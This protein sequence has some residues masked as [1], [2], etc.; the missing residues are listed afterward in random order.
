MIDKVIG[1]WDG[2]ATFDECIDVM[3]EREKTTDIH[4]SD[5]ISTH[6]DKKLF[7]IQNHPTTP[8]YVHGANQLMEILG[9][10]ERWD[11]FGDYPQ[12]EVCDHQ[13]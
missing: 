5:F 7:L 13:Y 3:K 6:R 8:I 10:E 12:R 9:R 2:T 1:G 4:L 11:P